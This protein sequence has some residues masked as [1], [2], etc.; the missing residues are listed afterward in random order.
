MTKNSEPVDNSRTF[1]ANQHLI[2]KPMT[3]NQCNQCKRWT[4]QAMVVGFPIRID[5]TAL[6]LT[7]ELQLRLQGVKIFQTIKGTG[8][9]RYLKIRR[10]ADIGQGYGYSI[11]AQHDCDRMDF[12]VHDLTERPKEKTE[13]KEIPF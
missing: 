7:Q 8:W 13:D 9:E 10:A 11:H 2:E 12:E 5:P 1:R 3:P 6:N 4:Y